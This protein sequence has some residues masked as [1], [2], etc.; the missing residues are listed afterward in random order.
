VRV[1]GRLRL[2]RLERLAR[3]QHELDDKYCRR[4]G[5]ARRR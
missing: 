3:E 4:R 1:F 2:E 5:T